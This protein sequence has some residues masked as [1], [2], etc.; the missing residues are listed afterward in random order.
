MANKFDWQTEDDFDWEELNN[1]QAAPPRKRRR[2]PYFLVIVAILAG[3]GYFA[4][5]QVTQRMDENTSAM[6]ADIISSYNLLHFAAGEQDNELFISLLSG[7]DSSWTNAQ[8]DLFSAG[9]LVDRSPFNL[10]AYGA[11]EVKVEADDTAVSFEFSPDLLAAEMAVQQDFMIDIGNGVTE[12]VTLQQTGVF[13]MGRERWLYSPPDTEFW[14]EELTQAGTMLTLTYPTRDAELAEQLHSDLERKLQ[15][16]CQTLGNDF[17]P[18][19]TTV[20]LTFSTDPATLAAT[21][22][23]PLVKQSKNELT[24]TLPTP[25]LVGVPTDDDSYDA[26]FRGYGVQL[27]TAVYTH[28]LGF[29]N[30]HTPIFRA[31]LDYQLDQ[32]ALKPW[33]VTASNYDQLLDEQIQLESLVPL[34]RS[35]EWTAAWEAIWPAYVIVDHLQTTYPDITTVEM[36]HTLV[37]SGDPFRWLRNLYGNQ[38]QERRDFVNDINLDLWIH[39]Y[40]NR[41]LINTSPPIP[42]PQQDLHLL[43]IQ[44]PTENSKETTTLYRYDPRQDNWQSEYTSNGEILL[45][46]LPNDEAVILQDFD[47]QNGNFNTILWQDELETSL[48][49]DPNELTVSLGQTNPAGNLLSTFIFAADDESANIYV[50]DLN[51]CVE[52]GCSKQLLPSIPIWSPN[53]E[54]SLFSEDPN[55]QISILHLDDRTV[56]FDPPYFEEDI[57]LFL[58]DKEE[59]FQPEPVVEVN[60]LLPAGSGYAP[61][62]L[63]EST[64]GFLQADSYENVTL[65]QSSVVGNDTQSLVESRDLMAVIPD[66]VEKGTLIMQYARLHP[67]D[68]NQLFI[69]AI[70]PPAAQS[71]LFLYNR[72]R[73]EL[74]WLLQAGSANHEL[75]IAP[76]GRYLILSGRGSNNAISLNGSASIMH[77]YDLLQAHSLPFPTISTTFPPILRFDWASDGEWVAL[78]LA[79]NTLG[80]YAPDHDYLKLIQVDF[81]NCHSPAWIN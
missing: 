76:N 16:A 53:G 8:N 46:K 72:Q 44:P 34:W 49:D 78:M 32:L 69:V 26:L 77:F 5:R 73:D 31:I 13:R 61:F 35:Q 51:N 75:G 74:T 81:G 22:E 52:N 10:F 38:F 12:T 71:H 47:T 23:L 24:L 59:L 4:W 40:R 11:D 41:Y 6:Q 63:D 36:L 43:C 27:V 9:L 19:D 29:G 65:M 42:W 1:S 80:L 30:I 28:L 39:A 57:E 2:W 70:N 50:F 25:S 58:G 18:S 45:S 79:N 15:S 37:R 17:C 20:T 62:W 21:N 67:T 60:D 3:L 48:L 14:G 56:L 33:P 64:I 66:H 54:Q 7:R 55:N 68:P